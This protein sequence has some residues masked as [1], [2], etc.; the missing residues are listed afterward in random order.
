[1]GDYLSY[2]ADR[3]AT[4]WQGRISHRAVEA[5][6]QAWALQSAGLALSILGV[7]LVLGFALAD[8]FLLGYLVASPL[9]FGACFLLGRAYEQ[10][11]AA[12]DEVLAQYSLPASAR[13]DFM[14]LSLETFEAKLAKHKLQEKV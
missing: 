13:S 2:R 11:G 8:S 9:L 6:V 14:A 7:A 3:R 12:A 4:A 10:R 1:M 5:T